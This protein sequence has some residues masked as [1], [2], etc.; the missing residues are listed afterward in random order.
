MFIISSNVNITSVAACE[1][2]K[3]TTRLFHFA[4]TLNKFPNTESL[5]YLKPSFLSSIFLTTQ[6]TINNR[7]E[8]TLVQYLMFGVT[9]VKSLPRYQ[10]IFFNDKMQFFKSFSIDSFEI[11]ISKSFCYT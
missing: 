2:S 4:K 11:M 9:L 6:S 1:Y 5:C 10:G 7:K 8:L 3:R